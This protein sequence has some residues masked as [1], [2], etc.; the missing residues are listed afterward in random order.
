MDKDKDLK[1]EVEDYEL[2][3]KGFRQKRM[4]AF[5]PRI[6]EFEKKHKPL[7]RVVYLGSKPVLLSKAITY[8]SAAAAVLLLA[9]AAFLLY[10]PAPDSPFLSQ[11][12][13]AYEKPELREFMGEG[14]PEAYNEAWDLFKEGKYK[15]AI[16]P[17][18]SI[19]DDNR[20]Y[21][22]AQFILGICYFEQK[23]YAKSV[24]SLQKVMQQSDKVLLMIKKDDI[25]DQLSPEHIDWYLALAY[26]AGDQER[27][28]QRDPLFHPKQS[29]S[30]FLSGS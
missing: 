26:L 24:E 8:A 7:G 3:L 17:L 18:E 16:P 1:Q 5:E 4:E 27:G 10:P 29:R 22:D 23:A 6:A 19:R 20:K 2:I 14:D 21:F 15:Q 13:Q 12:L 30:P 9:V 28:R 25:P 11:A